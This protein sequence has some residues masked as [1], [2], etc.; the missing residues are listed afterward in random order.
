VH[1]FSRTG[2]E[3]RVSTG[4]SPGASQS[5]FPGCLCSA[6]KI[7][8]TRVGCR[9]EEITP[10]ATP[11]HDSSRAATKIEAE[12]HLGPAEPILSIRCFEILRPLNE[13]SPIYAVVRRFAG[14][15]VRAMVAGRARR[16]I[17]LEAHSI[18]LHVDANRGEKVVNR[19]CVR[20]PIQALKLKIYS[21]TPD[22]HRAM[23]CQFTHK[24]A[25]TR[26][27]RQGQ[28][29]VV[30]PLYSGACPPPY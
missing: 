6:G 22:S 13:Q 3:D 21:I 18:C 9:R 15:F 4:C 23:R 17:I 24:L 1:H 19:A 14:N 5:V 29:L 30:P 25:P 20:L 7:G 27:R 26:R 11:G 16:S 28:A 8:W 10:A 2:H 12:S